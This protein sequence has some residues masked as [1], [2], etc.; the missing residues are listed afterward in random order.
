VSQ[1]SPAVITPNLINSVNIWYCLL[2][3]KLQRKIFTPSSMRLDLS[4][5]ATS[6]HI[7]TLI[8]IGYLGENLKFRTCDY[9]K[10]KGK[11]VPVLHWAPCHVGVW[12]SKCIAPRFLKIWLQ[13]CYMYRLLFSGLCHRIG[14]YF[15]FRTYRPYFRYCRWRQ[16]FPPKRRVTPTWFIWVTPYSG[17]YR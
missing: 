9:I 15:S 12:R 10:V 13:E 6:H 17:Y 3:C 4:D 11:I 5:Y 14:L 1:K 7:K 8:F 16:H 2:G